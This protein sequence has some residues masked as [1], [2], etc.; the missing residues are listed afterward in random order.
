MPVSRISCSTFIS[1]NSGA[2]WWIDEYLRDRN[3]GEGKGREE[4]GEGKKEKRRK[5]QR[6]EEEDRGKRRETEGRGGTQR[7]DEGGKEEKNSGKCGVKFTQQLLI[8]RQWWCFPN[9][10][11]I[12]HSH[13]R[14][15]GSPFVDGF[16]NDIDD[17]SQCFGPNRN[18][19]GR[20]H[21]NTN[22][23]SHQTLCPIHSNSSHGVLTWERE[24]KREEG[25]EGR[26]GWRY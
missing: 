25:R 1:T 9:T 23:P 5:R 24:R 7:K 14:S 17:T 11:C 16:S 15:Y 2:S 20:T 6:K 8:L 12:L 22:L 10:A 4:E 19:D 13:V 21:I 3:K 26:G 18:S